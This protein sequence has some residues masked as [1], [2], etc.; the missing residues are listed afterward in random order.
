[1]ECFSAVYGRRVERSQFK[2]LQMRGELFNATHTQAGGKMASLFAA[3]KSPF[4]NLKAANV[5]AIVEWLI[6]N[7][8][9]KESIA[10]LKKTNYF[11]IL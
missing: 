4:H 2:F 6:V 1:M 8:T 3:K 5:L 10:L 7:K 11:C 9:F